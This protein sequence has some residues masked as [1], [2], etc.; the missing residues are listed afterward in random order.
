MCAAAVD[1]DPE[2]YVSILEHAPLERTLR[3][4]AE[5]GRDLGLGDDDLEPYGRSRAK[6]RLDALS[7]DPVG[8]RGRYVLVTGITPTPLGEGKT[9]LAIGLAQA[10]WRIGVRSVV[11]VRQP[12]LGPVFGIKGG[13]TGGGRAQVIPADEINL[14]LTGDFHAV[15]AAH[16]TA[17]AFLDNHLHHGNALEIDPE[18][19]NWKRVLDVNDRA[20]REIEIGHGKGNGPVRRTGF[21]ITAASEVMAI[22]AMATDLADLRARLGRIVL[23]FDRGGDPVTAEQIGA[24]GA[25]AA[26]LRDAIKPNLLQT[27]EG[28][29]ALIHAGPFGNV[30]TGTSSI[31]ADRIGLR[32]ADV[33]LTEA[34]FGTDLGGEKFFNLK[35]RAAGLAPDVAILVATIR[36]LK[37]LS[38]A[39]KVRAG[40]ALDPALLSENLE[41]L[42]AGI[43]NFRKHIE[44][45]RRHGVRV[46]VAINAFPTDSPREVERVIAVARAAGAEDAVVADVFA[47]GG[48]GG[49]ELARAVLTAAERGSEFRLLYELD[50]PLTAKIERI[51]TE[52]YG[53]GAVEYEPAAQAQIA[54]CERAGLGRLPI[55]MAKT[56]YSFTGDPAVKG[57]PEGFTLTVRDLK[58][59]AGAGFVTPLVGSVQTMPGLGVSPAGAQIDLD[60]EGEVIGLV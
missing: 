36:G 6:V 52:M 37:A 33:V 7:G 49:I 32:T 56:P 2:S 51:A 12:S 43:P 16:N 41:A 39:I 48:E 20:L 8:A 58:I 45:V 25:M 4:I 46:V 59:A 40:R 3:P 22:L 26:L 38:P 35:C 13:G 54:R 31:I 14:H 10:F 5:V 44:N 21:E 29:P 34:G 28:T 1:R 57:R 27:L 60:A 19:I 15:T 53:A 30:A 17:S 24:A 11:N 23:A 47:Q 55:C 50:L 18:A 42:E 9:T